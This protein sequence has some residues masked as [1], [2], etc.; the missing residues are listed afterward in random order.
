MNPP[1]CTSYSILIT[2]PIQS[3]DLMRLPERDLALSAYWKSI[4][5]AR[6]PETKRIDCLRPEITCRI[7]CISLCLFVFKLH[8]LCFV[9]AFIAVFAFECAALSIIRTR[10]ATAARGSSFG[11]ALRN[12][13]WR[14]RAHTRKLKLRKNKRAHCETRQTAVHPQK[15][16]R[17]RIVPTAGNLSCSPTQQQIDKLPTD[18][19]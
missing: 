11:T 1:P 12:G 16:Q 3:R 7:R 15:P 19:G 2:D 18:W 13:R 14:R 5:L 10:T 4:W 8:L 9:A 6:R 17:K